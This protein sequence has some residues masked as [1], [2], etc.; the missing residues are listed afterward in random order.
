MVLHRA[1]VDLSETVAASLDVAMPLALQKRIAIDA[2]GVARE[3]V[4]ADR[5]AIEKVLTSL[6]RN[7][8]K[9]TPNDGQVAVRMRRRP[10]AVHI[11]VEDT[12]VG[13]A[14]NALPHITKPF[15]QRQGQLENGMKGSGLGLA[16][17]RSLIELHG[18]SLRIRSR[19]GAGT[20]VRV[21]LPLEAPPPMLPFLDAPELPRRAQAG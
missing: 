6:L 19:L 13:I 17:A 11:Y 5:S 14:R 8:V 21:I 10:G 1:D 16:I 9:Y 12:G 7:A 3:I 4:Y 15:E 18:G 2:S 20:V